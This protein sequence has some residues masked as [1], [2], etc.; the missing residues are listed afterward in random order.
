MNLLVTGGAGY[1]GS[2]MVKRLLQKGDLVSVIDNL[3]RGCREAIDQ[4]ARFYKGDIL[5]KKF[6]QDV[7]SKD[8]YDAVIHFA[9]YIL[10]EESIKLPYLYFQNNVFGSLNVIDTAV[11]NGVKNII[12]SSTAGIYGNPIK[13]PIPEDHPKNPENPYGESKLMVEKILSWYAKT[14]ELNFIALRYFNVAGAGMEGSMGKG[15]KAESQIIPNIMK[16]I[17]QKSPF[18]LFGD[19]YK[20]PDGT[21]I[22]DYIHVLDL[23]ESHV[24]AVKKLKKQPGSYFYNVGT[25]KGYSNKEVIKTVKRVTK[26]DFKVEIVKRRP[27]DVACVIADPAKI[28]KEL[29]F[30]PRYSD[31]KTIIET[32]WKW[33]KNRQQT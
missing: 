23:V 1:I 12:F 18:K 24:L 20:T 7:L 4:K 29:G 5:D 26:E 30:K 8:K 25:G 22:R 14:K 10:T 2:F 9:G 19:D 27:G 3:E 13:I 28:K 11:E 31:L 33:Y 6:L 32:E 21:C 16:A 17:L 15:D